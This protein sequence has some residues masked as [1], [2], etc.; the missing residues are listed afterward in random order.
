MTV[1]APSLLQPIPLTSRLR[2]CHAPEMRLL[3]PLGRQGGG[4]GG[5][6]S[7]RK[8][9]E[10]ENFATLANPTAYTASRTHCTAQAPTF[11]QLP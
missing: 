10:G 4:G 8:I 2:L 5:V 11:R 3:P 7:L 6:I 1:A 9:S